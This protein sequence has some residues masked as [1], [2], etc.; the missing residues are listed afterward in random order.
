M[1]DPASKSLLK[2]PNKNSLPNFLQRD[3]L[4]KIPDVNTPSK[5][6]EKDIQMDFKE[7]FIDPGQE[8]LE[9]LQTSEAEKNPGN[10]KVD[11]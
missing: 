6:F 11:Q 7:D 10:F 8:Y 1:V 2:I 5:G 9:R 3:F 4:S